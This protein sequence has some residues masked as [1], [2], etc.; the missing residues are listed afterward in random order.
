MRLPADV[1]SI[2]EQLDE[3]R[4]LKDQ[5][6]VADHTVRVTHP[7]RVFWP[8]SHGYPAYTKRDL[9]KYLVR[10]WPLLAPHLRDRPLTL[11]RYPYGLTGKH[12][13][14]KHVEIPLPDFVDREC[15]FAEQHAA[16]GE[17]V[18]CNNL[19]TLVWLGQ[20]SDIELHTWYSRRSVEPD[21]H[22]LPRTFAG[23][24]EALE[25]SVL[26]Y[27]D[28]MVFDL[29]PY[30]YSGRE[31]ARE[32]P[33][34]HREGFLRTV[35]P[36]FWLKEVLDQLHLPSFVKTSGKTGLHIFVPILRQLNY[37]LVRSISEQICRFVQRQHPL[38]TTME[39][40]V[41]KR[42]GKVFLDHNQN[43]RGK[44][45]ACAYS[46]RALP[47]APV[48]MPVRWDELA[49]VYPTDFLMSNA[50]ERLDRVGDLWR[51]ILSAKADL[52]Q[53]FGATR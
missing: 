32:E 4:L 30:V 11:K 13:F 10:A 36:A 45:L 2:L 19:A 50:F 26:N 33:Q 48:S 42:T 16:S 53:A 38:E 21:A 44:T 6:R 43:T 27:P 51:D 35:E 41:E 3:P 31:R 49:S 40:S 7:E 8:A 15:M 22:N 25:A 29:D 5:L 18:I 14:Q 46:P 9:L 1:R 17:N 23:S 37:D 39:W 34:L 47:G 28:F 52:S 12:F 20:M 24:V